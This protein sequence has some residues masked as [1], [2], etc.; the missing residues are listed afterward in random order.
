MFETI[1]NILIN[2]CGRLDIYRYAERVQVRVCAEVLIRA[3]CGRFCFVLIRKQKPQIPTQ[4]RPQQCNT[5]SPRTFRCIDEPVSFH[6]S[7]FLHHDLLFYKRHFQLF[8]AIVCFRSQLN[9][10]HLGP[11]RHHVGVLLHRAPRQGGTV[12]VDLGDLGHR[13][14][15][16]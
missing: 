7:T 12:V 9:I 2:Q 13:G 8:L 10:S 5:V 16:R 1:L 14:L 3:I 11:Q 6:H 15:L 4:S